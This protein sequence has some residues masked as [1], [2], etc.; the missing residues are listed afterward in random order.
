MLTGRDSKTEQNAERE[1][2]PRE[3]KVPGKE[4]KKNDEPGLNDEDCLLE[5]VGTRYQEVGVVAM[6]E[7]GGD[8]REQNQQR[9][10]AADQGFPDSRNRVIRGKHERENRP[11]YQE[12]KYALNY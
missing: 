1:A 7:S 2:V 5:E 10:N 4:E 8:C 6:T 9:A 3:M 12:L 11:Y